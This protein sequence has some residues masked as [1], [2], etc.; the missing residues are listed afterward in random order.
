MNRRGG[1][2]LNDWMNNL[3]RKLPVLKSKE[4]GNLGPGFGV[5]AGCGIGFGIGFMGGSCFLLLKLNEVISVPLVFYL[6]VHL[7]ACGAH[8]SRSLAWVLV[9]GYPDC[10]LLLDPELDVGL[11]LDLVMAMAWAGAGVLL[12]KE[13]FRDVFLLSTSVR[14]WVCMEVSEPFVKS[15]PQHGPRDEIATLIDKFATNTKTLVEATYKMIHK[16]KGF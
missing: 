9:L 10:S 2:E 16:G 15:C 6:C 1:G 14:V 5:G 13:I 7:R 8:V 12:I 3:R 4:L 11:V